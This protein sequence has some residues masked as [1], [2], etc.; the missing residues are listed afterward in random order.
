M[1]PLTAAEKMH[2]LLLKYLE[3]TKT[4]KICGTNNRRYMHVHTHACTHT[5]PKTHGYKLTHGKGHTNIYA[6]IHTH[7]CL[8]IFTFVQIIT[9]ASIFKNVL[10]SMMEGK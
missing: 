6:H 4:K 10:L 5:C 9:I 8:G 1:P 2:F 7:T 3:F